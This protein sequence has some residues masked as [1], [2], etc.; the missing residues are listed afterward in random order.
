MVL[1]KLLRRKWVTR[2]WV[3][4]ELAAASAAEA[5]CGN[6]S[7]SWS[8]LEIAFRTLRDLFSECVYKNLAMLAIPFRDFWISIFRHADILKLQVAEQWRHAG[9]QHALVYIIA[10]Y[11]ASSDVTDE[12][13]KLYGIIG[14]IQGSTDL[15][16][17]SLT[18]DYCKSSSEVFVGLSRYL[19]EGT[20]CL[21]TLYAVDG[22]DNDLPSW[23]PSWT[24]VRHP[25]Y[26]LNG[27]TKIQPPDP[28]PEISKSADNILHVR[29]IE[30]DRIH[31]V[32]S[33][34]SVKNLNVRT[35]APSPT[36]AVQSWEREILDSGSVKGTGK[37]F[38]D[39]CRE[40]FLYGLHE[41]ETEDNFVL[42]DGLL[43]FSLSSS[44]LDNEDPEL[45]YFAERALDNVNRQRPFC[46]EHWSSRENL[47][48][49][50]NFGGRRCVLFERRLFTPVSAF[51]W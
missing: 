49:R 3:L 18:P 9:Q 46:H 48:R 19:I 33:K 27:T 40:V 32:G 13:D 5:V 16:D 43:G 22:I 42:Y 28:D 47:R 45:Q 11:I 51:R 44:E 39:I 38:H 34:C 2:V 20:R 30:V 36:P 4:Q 26:L 37:V 14:I 15:T 8:V 21:S 6:A 23:V 10:N 12:R 41:K 1:S 24:E 25:I 29:S 35:A 50:G 31:I 17:P 7:I